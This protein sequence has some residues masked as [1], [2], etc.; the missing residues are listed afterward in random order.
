MS[1]TAKDVDTQVEVVV[2]I[3]AGAFTADQATA[4][5]IPIAGYRKALVVVNYGTIT[6]GTITPSVTSCA[7]LGGSYTAETNVTAVTTGTSATDEVSTV[8]SIDTTKALGFVKILLSETVASAGWDASA[9]LVG[10]LKRV[11]SAGD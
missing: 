1:F 9:T 10:T 8:F 5:G 7:T 2:G 11:N 3:P 4:A 6:D